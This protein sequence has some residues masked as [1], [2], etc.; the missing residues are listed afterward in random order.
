MNAKNKKKSPIH[1]NAD[2]NITE[3][4]DFDDGEIS[5]S[6]SRLPHTRPDGHIVISVIVR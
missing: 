4:Y 1:E 2:V 5:R 6:R 3:V